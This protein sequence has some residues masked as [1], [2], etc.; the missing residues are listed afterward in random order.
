[1]KDETLL[2]RG[3]ALEEAFFNKYNDELLAKLRAKEEAGKK[4]RSLA[5][6]TG[7]QDEQVLVDLLDAGVEASTLA[8]LAIAPLVL[9]AWRDG[10]IEERERGAILR[11]ADEQGLA[12]SSV[13][14]QLIEKWLNE[15]PGDTLTAAWKG[16]VEALRRNLSPEAFAALRKDI[17]T[18]TRAVARAAGGYLGFGAV[19]RAE[20]ELL[21]KLEEILR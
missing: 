21:A 14:Y 10:K 11:A 7:I 13:A 1:M 18:R 12:R 16:Y 9:L 4:K 5:D 17:L 19:T 2:K 20:K 6:A 3:R 15:R 8:A